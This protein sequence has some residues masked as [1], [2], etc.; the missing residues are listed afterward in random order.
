MRELKQR[1]VIGRLGKARG[2]KGEVWLYPTTDQINRFSKLTR[3]F[4]E[5]ERGQ[6]LK[7]LEVTSYQLAGNKLCLAFAGYSD[8]DAAESLTGFYLS[9]DRAEAVPLEAGEYYIADLI[10]CQVYDADRGLL[11]QVKEVVSGVGADVFVVHQ[12]GQKDLL[13]P[14]LKTIVKKVD[15]DGARIDLALPEGLYEIYRDS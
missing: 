14:N 13:C 7:S 9:V 10:G 8:R 12:A 6:V 15:I 11:G 5:D 2:L 4:A 1:L 3:C